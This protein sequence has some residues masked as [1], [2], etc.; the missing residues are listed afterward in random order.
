[1][2]HKLSVWILIFMSRSRYSEKYYT[3]GYE[4]KNVYIVIQNCKKTHI[5]YYIIKNYYIT[6]AFI[7]FKN[8][9]LFRLIIYEISFFIFYECYSCIKESPAIGCYLLY[10]IY[11]YKVYF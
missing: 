11:W 9:V 3:S 1:M 7:F 6:Y 8:I 5:K 2:T 4:I 10:L